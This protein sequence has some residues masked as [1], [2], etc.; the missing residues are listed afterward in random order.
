MF[1]DDFIDDEPAATAHAPDLLLVVQH[2]H[3]ARLL[4]SFALSRSQFH[5]RSRERFA[6]KN[7]ALRLIDG[8]VLNC[9]RGG[10]NQ[11]GIGKAMKTNSD[12]IAG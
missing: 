11:R 12:F 2:A 5:R 7:R 3:A 8:Q 1:A 6:R 4:D 10:G 9:K